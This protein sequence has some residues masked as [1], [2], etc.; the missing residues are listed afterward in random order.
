MLT[1]IIEGLIIALLSTMVLRWL[2]LEF[3]TVPSLKKELQS[4]QKEYDKL[5]DKHSESERKHSKEV[6]G[7]KKKNSDLDTA[8]KQITFAAEQASQWRNDDDS[9]ETTTMQDWPE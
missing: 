2:Y 6:D 5:K 9:S 4:N 3:R 8:N 1:N 7:L